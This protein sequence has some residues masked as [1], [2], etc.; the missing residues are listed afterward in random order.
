M[1]IP[2]RIRYV[3][4]RFTNKVF[5][6]LAGKKHSPFA[7]LSHR[8]RKSGKIY[9]IPVLVIQLAEGFVFALTYGSGVDWYLNVV[10]ANAAELKWQGCEYRLSHPRTLEPG[11]GRVLFG[12]FKGRILK[13]FKVNEFVIMDAIVK[14]E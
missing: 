7:L 11:A 8:G 4:K 12:N 2:D 9:Q 10:A 5:I 3:N 13:I 6:R 1:P 14:S